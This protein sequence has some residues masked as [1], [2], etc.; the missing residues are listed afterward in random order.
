MQAAQM[1]MARGHA[2][3][4]AEGAKVDI[5]ERGA[6]N[7]EATEPQMRGFHFG[8]VRDAILV[9][10]GGRVRRIAARIVSGRR[11]DKPSK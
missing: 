3:A 4:E 8:W 5:A 7:E 9:Y 2:M 10:L 11:G 1:M 6:A